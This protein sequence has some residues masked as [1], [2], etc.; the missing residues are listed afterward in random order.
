ML[1][2]A[3]IIASCKN[4]SYWELLLIRPRRGQTKNTDWFLHPKN[5]GYNHYD[6]LMV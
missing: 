6:L 5:K 3:D 4:N 2:D 1:A